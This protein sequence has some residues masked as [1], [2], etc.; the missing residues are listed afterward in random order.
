MVKLEILN[1]YDLPAALSTASVKE[2]LRVF[3]DSHDAVIDLLID[4]AVQFVETFT[5]QT[6]RRRQ[7]RMTSDGVVMILQHPLQ[8]ID[9]IEQTVGGSFVA[10][11]PIT[12][13]Q[14]T[15]TTPPTVHLSKLASPYRVTYTAGL[16]DGDWPADLVLLIWQMVEEHFTA[17]RAA[18]DKPHSAK[19]SRAFQLTLEQYC[20]HHDAVR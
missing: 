12:D 16:P 7:Y 11:D 15:Q 1:Q 17:R 2:Y 14:P 3:D 20:T 5:R 10:V 19:F 6:F 13:Y 18:P 8:S 4:A 9:T